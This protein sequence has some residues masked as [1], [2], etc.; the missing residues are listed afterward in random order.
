MARPKKTESVNTESKTKP[1]KRGRPPG[2][3]M[4]KKGIE[5]IMEQD[6]SLNSD[7][8]PTFNKSLQPE[9]Y[10]NILLQELKN[11]HK[12]KEKTALQKEFS[13]DK[14][15]KPE[16]LEEEEEDY[17]IEGYDIELP[18][19]EEELEEP[20]NSMPKRG[21]RRRKKSSPDS[22]DIEEDFYESDYFIEEEE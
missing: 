18:E 21:K 15:E 17:D 20:N 1:K 8:P 3:T 13:L 14:E 5:N 10:D 19:L 12:V 16:D 4:S 2:K 11:S 6:I 22:I 7:K 9:E